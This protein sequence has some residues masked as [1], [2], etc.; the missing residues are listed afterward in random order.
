MLGRALHLYLTL[1]CNWGGFWPIGNR[2]VF[3]HIVRGHPGG[4]LHVSKGA[5][6]K[7][8]LGSISS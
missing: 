8:F 1:H 5:A 3:I 2:M 7:I 6:V 4:L